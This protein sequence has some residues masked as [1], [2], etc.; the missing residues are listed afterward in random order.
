VSPTQPIRTL[1]VAELHTVLGQPAPTPSGGSAAALA[2]AMAAALVGLVARASRDWPEAPG[3]AAQAAAL[4]DRLLGLADEDAAA[5][6]DALAELRAADGESRRSGLGPALL[7][8]TDVPLA[9]ADACADV[10][11]LAALARDQ[12]RP[13]VRPDAV[14]ARELAVAATRG[15]AQLV[16]ANLATRPGDDRSLRATAATRAAEATAETP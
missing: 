6:A 3:V 13:A 1:T 12:G 11:A 16:N 9:I 8:A 15:A 4:E 5:F 7:R 10:A 2:G 14:V